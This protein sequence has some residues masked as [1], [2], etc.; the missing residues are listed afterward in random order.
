MAA[1]EDQTKGTA[2]DDAS[3]AA[4]PDQ[5]RRTRE[6]RQRAAVTIDLTAADVP[7]N[8]GT[9][10]AADG[11][12]IPSG[13]PEK[14]GAET[15]ERRPPER[16]TEGSPRGGAAL[17]GATLRAP[18]WD[19]GWRRSLLAGVVGGLIALLVVIVLQAIGL[20]PAP[21]RSAANQAAEQAKAASDA[22]FALDRRVTAVETMVEGLPAIRTDIK[23]LSDRI[24]ELEAARGTFASHSDIATVA[25]ALA[26]LR[27]T[28]DTAPPAAAHDD[29]DAL[30]ARVGRLEIIPVASGDGSG[31]APDAAVS[32]LASQLA[33]TQKAL[34]SL[35]DR[36]AAAEA[37]TASLGMPGS[38]SAMKA[39][40]VAS[41]RQAAAGDQPFTG[42]VDLVGAA[43]LGG[44]DLVTLR[45]IAEKGAAS[46][47]TLE[48]EFPAVADAILAASTAS[49]PNAGFLQRLWVGVSSLV[50]IRP[51]GPVAGSDPMA[52]VSRMTAAVAGGDFA[53][54]LRERDGLPQ[55]GKD[56]SA[57]WAAKAGD[58]A[59]LNALVERIAAS[60]DQPKTE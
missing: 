13:E 14:S 51:A 45:A 36:V 2:G 6:R 48:R 56:T 39:I 7:A 38:D 37:K 9:G 42:D 21:G 49:D 3:A 50:S 53:T 10:N 19:E 17:P 18:S 20:V 35:R 24:G 29:L 57:G 16:P 15:A 31:A 26:T 30:A 58:R 44:D 40:A 4:K 60:L 22:A 11:N 59:T 54:A 1:D 28:V 47:A 5:E 12:G 52:I 25:S 43:G 55:A 32:S 34:Q 46:A 23:S 33:D 41:L 27:Q 8:A